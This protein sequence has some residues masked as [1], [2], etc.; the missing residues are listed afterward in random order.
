MGDNGEKT[1]AHELALGTDPELAK[2]FLAFFQANKEKGYESVSGVGSSLHETRSIREKLPQLFKLLGISSMVDAPCGDFH[3]MHEL[4]YTFQLYV[5]VE[6]VPDLVA[7]NREMVTKPFHFF[8]IADITNAILPKVDAIFCRDCLVHLSNRLVTRALDN[9]ARSGSRYLIT[10]HFVDAGDSE[11]NSRMN[12][13]IGV[14]KWRPV[15]LTRAPFGLTDPI[16]ILDEE[17]KNRFARGKCLG[18]WRLA[19]IASHRLM[20]L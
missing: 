20:S 5:G 19:D 8:E 7:R 2:K 10:T 18:V 3:W 14:G 13:D 1:P 4:D 15:S 11:L 6:L 9:F 16:A 12:D 17:S